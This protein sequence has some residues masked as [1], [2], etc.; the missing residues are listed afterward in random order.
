MMKSAI[1]VLVPLLLVA[2]A[3]YAD[4]HPSVQMDATS[5]TKQNIAAEGYSIVVPPLPSICCQAGYEVHV[6]L[7]S[8]DNEVFMKTTVSY[9]CQI[10]QQ[11]PC[12][13]PFLNRYIFYLSIIN[14]TSKAR[15]QVPSDGWV[16][17]PGSSYNIILAQVAPCSGQAYPA[18]AVKATNGSQTFSSTICGSLSL[19]Q[20]R[21]FREAVAGMLEVHNLTACNQLPASGETQSSITVLNS[22]GR[23]LPLSWTPTISPGQP[24]CGFNLS[25]TNNN[26]NVNVIWNSTL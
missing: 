6:G 17:T 15:V 16:L 9:G 22:A 8:T 20:G 4:V 19:L 23:S 12:M 10:A 25:F 5:T 18:W 21:S 24:D 7:S 13:Q 26:R 3:A 1:L 14:Q 11:K 2:N